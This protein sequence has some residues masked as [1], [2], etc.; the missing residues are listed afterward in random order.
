MIIWLS[1]GK[2]IIIMVFDNSVSMG[3]F[4]YFV[5]STI[6]SQFCRQHGILSIDI[7]SK[8]IL[9]TEIVYRHFVLS[10]IFQVTIILSTDNFL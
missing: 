4:T 6:L 8:D 10:T 7:M 2:K 5:D 3:V 1:V 9:S